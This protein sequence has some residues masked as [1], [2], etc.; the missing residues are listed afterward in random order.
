VEEPL[1][2]VLLLRKANAL[3][4]AEFLGLAEDDAGPRLL[5][6]A[7]RCSLDRSGWA[8]ASVAARDSD[9]L[10]GDVGFEDEDWVSR[11]KDDDDDCC[12]CCCCLDEGTLCLD[13]VV[14]ADE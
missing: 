1:G 2:T 6:L 13:E 10:V 11:F 9:G 3:I 7:D 12:C 5:L 4:S 14:V 8:V